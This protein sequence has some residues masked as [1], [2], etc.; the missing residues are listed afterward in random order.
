MLKVCKTFINYIIG[1]YGDIR[2]GVS[3]RLKKCFESSRK[4]EL[5]GFLLWLG[6]G[7]RW[8]LPQASRGL[9]NLSVLLLSKEGVAK[10]SNQLAQM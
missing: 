3:S 9:H 1:I 7:L 8:E 2:T 10:L 5:S 4:G 6:A